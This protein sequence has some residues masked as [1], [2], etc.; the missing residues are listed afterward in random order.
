MATAPEGQG[1]QV[2]IDLVVNADTIPS[3]LQEA[4][5]VVKTG[6]AEMANAI[7]AGA[8]SLASLG[9]AEATAN[10]ERLKSAFGDLGRATKEELGESARASNAFITTLKK[11]AADA[12]AVTQSMVNKL[13]GQQAADPRLQNTIVSQYIESLQKLAN[14]NK[15]VAAATEQA[16]AAQKNQTIA[17]A[18]AAQQ[19]ANFERSAQSARLELLSFGKTAAEK[20]EIRAKL[21]GIDKTDAT[22]KIIA[23]LREAQAAADATAATLS[24]GGVQAMD[25]MGM[26]AKG[27]AAAMRSVPAQVTDI[28]VGLQ[29]GQAP[30]TILLQQGGQLKDMFG[31][32]GNA[33]RAIGGYAAGLIT[34]FSAATAAVVALGYAAYQASEEAK[35]LREALILTGTQGTNSISSIAGMASALNDV[36]VS[37]STANAAFIAFISA[38]AKVDDNLQAV[39]KAAIDL[40][41]FGGA[42]ID[43]TAKK[44][45]AL[46]KDPLAEFD[47]LSLAVY[48]QI[49][50]LLDQGRATDAVVVAQ[51]A[52]I[53]STAETAKAL[54]ANQG[55][56]DNAIDYWKQ[57]GGEVW[58]TVKALTAAAGLRSMSG[59]EQRAQLQSRRDTYAALGYD[60]KEIDAQLEYF[61]RVDAAQKQSAENLARETQLK[62]ALADF[63]KDDTATKNQRAL[64]EATA[65]YAPLVEAQLLSAERYAE[66]IRKLS[67][68]GIKKDPVAAQP[69]DYIGALLAD[70]AK[71]KALAD[72]I[73]ANDGRA[74]TDSQK[75]AIQY[76]SQID[77][78]IRKTNKGSER[79][80]ELE[81]AAAAAIEARRAAETKGLQGK[82][83]EQYIADQEKAQKELAESQQKSNEQYVALYINAD[84]YTQSLKDSLSV[85]ALER[86]LTGQMLPV[87][88]ITISQYRNLLAYKQ[89][90]RDLDSSGV[91]VEQRRTLEAKY[92]A[93]LE[94]QNAEAVTAAWEKTAQS[95]NDAL[96][97][98]FMDAA[99][100]GKDIFRNL[101]DAITREFANLVI[102]PVI[103]GA[104]QGAT[105]SFVGSSTSSFAGSALG[106]ALGVEKVLPTGEL[107][108]SDS[109]MQGL[110][111]FAD[112]ATTVGNALNYLDAANSASEGRWGAAAGQALGT[113]YFGPIGGI[114]GKSVGDAI[115]K[116]FGG[117]GDGTP[118]R[119]LGDIRRTYDRS[120]NVTNTET[121]VFISDQ[122]SKTVKAMSDSYLTAARALGVT[123]ATSQFGFGSNNID[124]GKV[125][126]SSKVG[127]Q[128]Y[129]SGEVDPSLL[130]LVASRAVLSALQASDLPNYL[131]NVF[132]NLSVNDASKEAIEAAIAYAGTLKTVRESMIDVGEYTTILR[133]KVD[134]G[135]SA[136]KTSAQSFKDDFVAAIEAGL[137]PEQLTLWQQL[138]V[139]MNTLSEA[140]G[141]YSLA[142]RSQ[143]DILKERLT[144]QDQLDELTMTSTQ[145]LAKQRDALD[146]SNKALFDQ[147][148]NQERLKAVQEANVTWQEKLDLLTGA[149]TERQIAKANDLA[150]YTDATTQGLI[151]QYY[152]QL[153]LKD[154][155]KE[156]AAAQSDY[157]SALKNQATSLNAA[158]SVR[159]EATSA[160]LSAL[161]EVNA[162]QERLATIQL[163]AQIEIANAANEAAQ[164]MG[165]LG[166][167]LRNFV[168]GLTIKPSDSFA[169]ALT[170]ALGGDADAMKALPGLAT[171]AIDSAKL[172]SGD[173]TTF[174]IERAKIIAK[175]SAAAAVAEAAAL[176]TQTVPT[177]GDP[178]VEAQ[179]ALSEAQGRLAD[180]LAVA[181]TINAPLAT[182]VTDLIAKFTQAQADI[183]K[184]NADL[185]LS[186][187]KLD[188]IAGNTGTTADN[189]FDTIAAIL[190]VETALVE[191]VVGKFTLFDTS[192]NGL[193]SSEEFLAGM[194]GKATDAE[195]QEIYNRA[196]TNHDGQVTLLEALKASAAS[197]TTNTAKTVTGLTTLGTSIATSVTT[198][199]AGISPTASSVVTFAEDD[200][201]RSIFDNITKSNDLLIDGLQVQLT[202]LLGVGF[203]DKLEALGEYNSAFIGTYQLQASATGHLQTIAANSATMLTAMQNTAVESYNT[204]VNLLAG[205]RVKYDRAAYE[206][207]VYATGGAFTNGIVSRPTSFDVGLMGE[208][209]PEAIMPLVNI[210]GS[211]GVRS[212]GGDATAAEIRALR[213][214]Q[215]AQSSAFVKLMQRLTKL[216]ERWD[217]TGMPETRVVA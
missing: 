31:S 126:V 93:D 203:N 113:Y 152:A 19:F 146:E 132:D 56:I 213:E 12:S 121:Q 130:A 102:R 178:L 36:G 54:A 114:V 87:R 28:V 148:K 72:Q 46:A 127:D 71:Q 37:T 91:S 161:S 99:L 169:R 20:Y 51:K 141:D 79:R 210:N 81:K 104:V 10:V 156:A 138:A 154:A 63:N 90:L 76:A 50:A 123:A 88:E 3:T 96:T 64:N 201:I 21:L 206:S 214:E 98:A 24:K 16:A 145:L 151:E 165:D 48:R 167:E 176:K 110:S 166:K 4:T 109:A 84:K 163:N 119:N 6:T 42:A 69:Q 136:L 215:R 75:L 70:M 73:L 147:V 125:T 198:A 195:L 35:A 135:F 82:A 7:N 115:D 18:A 177:A 117:G 89:R 179:T 27:Y 174:A 137:T 202:Q 173:S 216:Q 30:M 188:L 185:L 22:Q 129:G 23:D 139:D 44:F 39:T 122:A 184:A 47:K 183:A 61:R 80:I 85:S 40:E 175:V 45:V 68:A 103:S 164:R 158:M 208:A 9:N 155:T 65:K 11:S 26:S 193:L 108:L 112:G 62:K 172:A 194:A 149:R 101:R 186:Q 134:S 140:T 180:A 128:F 150:K 107:Q 59:N 8:K 157:T 144:L 118:T 200:P 67:T 55:P 78:A 204:N 77:E 207:G 92:A 105:S 66:V 95:I 60:T 53:E 97:N 1:R 32:A 86:T 189:T 209:G 83:L 13:A 211:L 2:S 111:K 34:P 124:G 190:K 162:A 5:N 41:R 49:E 29:G 14:E 58:D 52:F 199:I 100:N 171:G 106:S 15:V 212:A 57:F 191:D 197:T 143:A 43:E 187:T 196:D 182:S 131:S 205:I 116:A 217:A 94:L 170:A 120:G 192:L 142:V 25:K 153:D 33:A 159:Q 168:D 74:L 133:S 17:T 181:N 160:Y 38:G